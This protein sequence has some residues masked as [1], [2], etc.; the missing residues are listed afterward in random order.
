MSRPRVTSPAATT[1][2]VRRPLLTA[3]VSAG[4]LVVVATPAVATPGAAAPPS[5]EYRVTGEV[6][7]VHEATGADGDEGLCS[8]PESAQ[9]DGAF[10]FTLRSTI[11]GLSD[12]A[13]LAVRE[14][15]PDGTVLRARYE[16]DGTLVQ[17]SGAHTYSMHYTARDTVRVGG[18]TVHFASSF[19]AIGHSEIGTPYSIR[20]SGRS[21]LVDGVPTDDRDQL[22]VQGCL[23]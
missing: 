18:D 14:S 19:T 1:R 5:Y 11:A 13:V 10:V 22:R 9:Y 3:A 8:T 17:R 23:P 7:E 12:A 21:V 2:L 15:E 20:Q 6:S 4:W 16:E